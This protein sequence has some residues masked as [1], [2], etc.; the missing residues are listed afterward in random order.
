MFPADDN[1]DVLSMGTPDQTCGSCQAIVWPAEFT[2][3]HVG[4]GQKSYS[5]CCSKGKVQLPFLRVPPFE[6]T[7][8][9]TGN[10][11]QAKMYFHKSRI[12]NTMFAFCSYGAKVD[13]SVNDG[14][15]PYVFRVTGQVY[16]NIA[17][18]VP[19]DGRAPKFAQLYMYDRYEANEHRINLTGDKGRVDKLI[20]A[21][22]DGML[23]HNN[24]LVGI[25]NQ[26]RQRFSSVEHVPVPLKLFERRT[27]DGRFHSSQSEEDYEIENIHAVNAFEFAGL[28][29]DND[30]ENKRY[31]VVHSKTLGLQH[32]SELHPCYMSLQYPLLFPFGEDGYRIGIK[33]RDVQISDNRGH[34]TVSMCEYYA[35]RTHYRVGEGH[36]LILGD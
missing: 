29:V 12:Y 4:P 27:S 28:A 10:D 18:L 2:G 31:I 24:V 14:R 36:A 19:P 35:F 6:L 26:I 5:I 17:S 15:G 22:L 3:R 33:H 21:T 13:E 9:L 16:H 7:R 25:F 34:N 20:V 11:I 8:L 32:I 23:S 1:N 30:F